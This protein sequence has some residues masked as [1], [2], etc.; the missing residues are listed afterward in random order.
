MKCKYCGEELENDSQ[1]CT[2]CGMR[3]DVSD[4]D[5]SVSEDVF[6]ATDDDDAITM[7]LDGN[8]DSDITDYSDEPD[9]LS[10]EDDNAAEEDGAE[11]LSDESES[12][13]AQDEASS[14]D[15]GQNV[16]ETQT[17]E[18]KKTGSADAGK[19]MLA[20]V[21]LSATLLAAIGYLFID[22]LLS[23][24]H[25]DSR[26][27]TITIVSQS[28]DITVKAGTP[29]EFFVDAHG[30]NLTYQ[31]YV[32]KS[33]EQLWHAWKNHDKPK[34]TSKSNESWDG[35]Q[36]YCMIIDNNRTSLASEIIT[37]KIEK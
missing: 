17:D 15:E 18:S 16:V 26:A 2:S 34:T 28:E 8:D 37:I 6:S 19:M 4:S 1:F 29:T 25:P 31:W 30:T 33:G 23:I 7:P 27:S 9:A 11:F 12:T 10:G 14:E 20:I 36:V 24:P 32:K 21:M 5:E 13:E 3:M 35:M 22:K